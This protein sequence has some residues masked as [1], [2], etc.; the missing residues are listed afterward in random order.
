MLPEI[1][2]NSLASLQPG[3]VRLTKTALIEFTPEGL[4]VGVELQNSAIKSTKRLTYEQV[5]AFIADSDAWHKKL[6]AKAHALL[7][8]MRALAKTLRTR[9]MKKGSLELDMPEVK[10][11]LDKS[12]QVAGAHVVENTE[13]HQIIEEF[14]L[15][16]NEA[17]ADT[18]HS[19]DWPFIRRVH[20][21]PTLRKLRALTAFVKELGYKVE[22]LESRFELQKLLKAA[23]GRPDQYAGEL[24]HAALV[25]ARGLQSN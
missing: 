12:G 9:R 17:V 16:A 3:K 20:R 11:E 4:R 14:M 8:Q 7:T 18:L 1:I 21:P 6:G 19:K 24:R 25:A 2:S 23:A 15:A 5:D 22:S 10:I 13:S